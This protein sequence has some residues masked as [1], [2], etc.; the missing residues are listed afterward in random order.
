MIL[1][2]TFVDAVVLCFCL[3]V[4]FSGDSGGSYSDSA[5]S[6]IFSFKNKD[7]LEPFMLHTKKTEHSIC[8]NSN[9]GPTFGGGH[10]FHNSIASVL[11]QIR[12][13]I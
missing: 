11:T 10:D 8:G 5:H 2:A 7:G 13:L 6:F 9:Y 4:C 1:I 12:T 3:F